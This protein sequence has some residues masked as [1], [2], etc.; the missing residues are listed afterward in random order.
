ML[1]RTGE[2]VLSV[3]EWG[4]SPRCLWHLLS[5]GF[6]HDTCRPFR[7]KYPYLKC[8]LGQKERNFPAQPVFGAQPACV[9]NE[10]RFKTAIPPPNA[11]W[12]HGLNSSKELALRVV[13]LL[14]QPAVCSLCPE[15]PGSAMLYGAGLVFCPRHTGQ[16]RS[17]FLWWCGERTARAPA[18]CI[19][20]CHPDLLPN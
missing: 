5:A 3:G 11:A 2:Q 16:G 7:S 6:S 4:G 19:C 12:N 18:V 20:P 13:S 1:G 15:V 17:P 10:C 8:K 14:S 9:V